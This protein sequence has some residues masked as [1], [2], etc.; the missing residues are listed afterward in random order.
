MHF[1]TFYNRLLNCSHGD[2]KGTTQ[3]FLFHWTF[4][5]CVARGF[6]RCHVSPQKPEGVRMFIS[7][8]LSLC[9][10]APCRRPSAVGISI[11]GGASFWAAGFSPSRVAWDFIT[12]MGLGFCAPRY[13]CSA[14]PTGK[15]EEELNYH[16]LENKC[17]KDNICWLLK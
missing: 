13:A 8:C 4:R 2:T 6:D 14:K 9:G 15:Q 5:V 12:S 7:L 1:D 10:R 16:I 17:R 3:R 11:L